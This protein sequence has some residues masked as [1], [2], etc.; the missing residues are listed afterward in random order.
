MT[1]SHELV[2]EGLG[3]GSKSLFPT[4]FYMIFLIPI[5]HVLMHN[6]KINQKIEVSI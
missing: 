3:V 1:A 4:S 6:I 2:K 5:L